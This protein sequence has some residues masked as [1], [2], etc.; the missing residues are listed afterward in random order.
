MP[1]S[2]DTDQ[3]VMDAINRLPGS[4]LEDIAQ[5]C[6]D[7]TWNQVFI[8][9]DNLSRLGAVRLTPKGRGLYTV[10]PLNS[11]PIQSPSCVASASVTTVKARND[12]HQQAGGGRPS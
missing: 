12:S 4:M 1:I 6:P 7:L 11:N 3:K 10:Q 2:Q 5:E 9:I 8:T